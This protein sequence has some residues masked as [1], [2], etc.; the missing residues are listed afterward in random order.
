MTLSQLVFRSMKKNI[1][2]YYLYFFALIFS[3]TLYFSFVTLQYNP[4]VVE[5]SDNIKISAGLKAASYLLLFV[6]IF[7]VLYANR[8]FMKRRSKE[9]GLYQL[10]GM[11]KGLV[12][13]LLV[14]EN[15]FL[16][17]SA[18]A[19]GVGL[20]FLSSR[21]FAMIL[22]HILEKD[23]LVQLIFSVE[24]LQMTIFVFL[25]LLII[26]LIQ[27]A[28][29]IRRV[30][31]LTLFTA[32]A[33]SEVN[34]KRFSGMQMLLGFIGIILIGYGYYLSTT[35]FEIDS[36]NVNMLL[37]KMIAILGSTIGGT[38][39][40][41]RFSV[42]FVLELIRKRKRGHLSI[43][44]VLSLSPIMHR[45]KSNAMSLT[46]I[47]IIS[48]TALGILCLSYISYYSAGSSAKQSIPFDYIVVNDQGEV[49]LEQLNEKNIE[50]LQTDIELLNVEVEKKELFTSDLPAELVAAT[51][52]L[53]PITKLSDVQKV[54][55]ELTLK[56][57]EGYII[58][59]SDMMSTII[60]WEANNPVQLTTQAG[61]ER[62]TVKELIPESVLSYSLT[63]AGEALVVTDEQFEKLATDSRIQEQTLWSKQVG[64]NLVDRSQLKE[65]QTIY[66]DTTNNGRFEVTK[67]D[68]V[69]DSVNM[70]SQEEFRL[71]MLDVY[72]LIIFVTGFLGLAFLMTTGSILYF[73]QM[74]EAEEEKASYTVLRKIGFTA[75]ELMK[76]IYIKQLFSFG[77]PLVIGLLHSYFA[78]KSGWMLFGTELVMPL[79]ITMSIYVILY[80][81]FAFLTIGYYRRVVNDSL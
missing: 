6:V 3:V 33:T 2:H 58:G 50:F 40:I 55:P 22:L 26:V 78:V 20:G 64:I 63:G 35:L 45:M 68:G 11:S 8:L 81:I 59:Y 48:A 66:E 70:A 56:E 30:S 67:E 52:G 51:K 24:A 12:T 53:I 19:I 61:E 34:V 32:N 37:Y 17:V 77:V 13:R 10:I 18:L 39:F 46:T 80:S 74:T 57:G 42:A 49:F 43:Q 9:I 15:A 21:I 7:F 76:G 47:T 1:R 75:N 36:D 25:A 65:V 71:S 29:G 14:L 41:F 16:W 79:L 27:T 60:K 44:D 69:V 5:V 28:I 23:V 73:K 38:Y 62:L 31:L 72:G 4:T 54:M